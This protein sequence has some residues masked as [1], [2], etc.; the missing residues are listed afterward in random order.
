MNCPKCGQPCPAGANYCAFCGAALGSVPVVPAR[1][2]LSKLAVGASAASVVASIW[3]LADEGRSQ[4]PLL[5]TLS[6]LPLDFV[7]LAVTGWPGR[8]VRGQ[9]FAGVGFLFLLCCLVMA[10]HPDWDRPRRRQAE[11]ESKLKLIWRGLDAYS[12]GRDHF[13][14]GDQWCDVLSDGGYLVAEGL[15]ICPTQPSHVGSSY[16]INSRMGGTHVDRGSRRVLL[17]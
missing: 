3:L 10:P 8:A 2:R 4:A 13:P 14:P 9:A 5:L 6:L 11:C 15:F 16:A 1:R 7:V 12:S 17:F